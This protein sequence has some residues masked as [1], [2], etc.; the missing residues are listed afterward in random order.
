MRTLF[1]DDNEPRAVKSIAKRLQAST[2][3]VTQA[4]ADSPFVFAAHAANTATSPEVAERAS[5]F[6]LQATLVAALEPELSVGARA[7]HVRNLRAI[8]AFIRNEIWESLLPAW[9]AN[10]ALEKNARRAIGKMESVYKRFDYL[11]E[12]V[13]GRPDLDEALS[14]KAIATL[15]PIL[16]RMLKM[17]SSIVAQ[18]ADVNRGSTASDDDILDLSLMA[19][20]FLADIRSDRILNIAPPA[21]SVSE[22]VTLFSEPKPAASVVRR[23]SARV[24][25]SVKPNHEPDDCVGCGT[26]SGDSFRFRRRSS[27]VPFRCTDFSRRNANK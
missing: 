14:E 18:V 16:E 3:A 4:L 11:L 23:S 8:F 1:A 5:S 15:T 25:T 26:D 6:P 13:A 19:A 20:N 22:L 10:R 21:I 7:M 2:D 17:M 27:P 12:S 9:Q 24:A